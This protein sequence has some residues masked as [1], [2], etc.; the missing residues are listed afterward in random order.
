MQAVFT[1]SDTIRQFEPRA[2]MTRLDKAGT[3]RRQECLRHKAFSGTKLPYPLGTPSGRVGSV[4]RDT[5]RTGYC[6]WAPLARTRGPQAATSSR[7][8]ALKRS[9][10]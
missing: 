8:K 1:A 2:T 7:T 9:G 10:V 4:P 5:A 6:G 3:A